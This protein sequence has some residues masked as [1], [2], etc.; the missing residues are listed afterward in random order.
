MFSGVLALLERALRIDSRAWGPHLA[1][2]L[3]MAAICVAVFFATATSTR[4]G[5]PG[6]RFFQSIA[7]LNLIFMTLM[8]VGYFSTAITEEKEEDTLGLML[9]AGISPLGILL[10]KSVGRLIQAFLLIAVQYPFTLLA[11]T[12]GGVTGSQVRS[13]YLA[14]IAYLIFL[15]G[16]GLLC[17]TLAPRNRLAASWMTLMILGY[18]VVPV[19]LNSLRV[20]PGSK[21]F[22]DL[23][24]SWLRD[25]CVL[26]QIKAI[27][28][29]GNEVE[30]F[31]H[32][33]ITN[34]AL[35]GIGFVLSW[36]LFGVASRVPSTEAVSRGLVMRPRGQLRVFSPGRPQV[37]PFVWK[38]FHFVAGGFAALLFRTVLFVMLYCV[39]VSA[40]QVGIAG[41]RWGP[42][43]WNGATGTYLT[44]MMFIVSFDAG[45]LVSR[46]LHEEVR[47]STLA[48]LLM[49]P[50]STGTILYSKMAG[51][52]L[53]W[54]PG[55]ACLLLGMLFLPGGPR[56]TGDF[57]DRSGPPYLFISFFVLAP[58][59]SALAAMYV[60]WGAHS[61]GIAATFGLG[62]MT[63]LFIS[64]FRIGP[65][66]AMVFV[67]GTAVYTLSCACHIGV[68]LR[69]ESL[70]AR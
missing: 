37:N 19:C 18:L 15:A 3:L 56:C 9:M 23:S 49:L 44:L 35:G 2:F 54:I 30:M 12:M 1:R 50:T 40:L 21:S 26:F 53:G 62:F 43:S 16:I 13:V 58:H 61:V 45:L 14:M 60:R 52:L 28:A 51:S 63:A 48:A 66:D 57:F 17:S 41:P 20:S 42:A 64:T 11:V 32:Q 34:F 10:G 33:V 25:S 55:P 59:L 31:S 39:I 6:L 68:W 8:G 36:L 46:S 47:Q 70:S 5:A 67:I 7:N 65:E 22:L 4:F 38:D 29:S 27:L 69:A 24:T